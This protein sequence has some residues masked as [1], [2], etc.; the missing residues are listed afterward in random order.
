M[1]AREE[2]I[3]VSTLNLPAPPLSEL[4]DFVRV[5]ALVQGLSAPLVERTLARIQSPAGEGAGAWPYEWMQEGDRTDRNLRSL[6]AA[7]CF[8]LA[9]FPFV[10]GPVRAQALKRC[11]EVFQQW[12]R[13]ERV[14]LERIEVSVQG[15]KVPAYGAGL[16]QYKAPLL[17]VMGGVVALKE[18]WHNFL[19][20]S[21][22][23]RCPVIVVDFPGAGE[24]GLTYHANSHEELKQAL[25]EL[26][27]LA[28]TGECIALASS[29][30]GPLWLRVAL[31]D[32]RVRGVI[33]H[34]SPIHDFFTDP[35]WWERVPMTTKLAMAS[36]MRVPIE[37]VETL[38]ST[39]ALPREELSRLELP[40]LY[41]AGLRDEIIPSADWELVEASAP[42]ARV[43]RLD[44]VHG[45]PN[46]LREA[47]L[48][49]MWNVL[50][51]GGKHRSPAGLLVGSMRLATNLEPKLKR[52]RSSS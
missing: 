9:R 27:Q 20:A 39:L 17:L 7:S 45:T 33:L 19:K 37:Q 13:T 36:C 30:S 34:G 24:S 49:I 12:A 31:S 2:S 43:F 8:N 44:D 28:G 4:K 35:A 42:R 1:M 48:E 50:R 22:F 51:I 15:R 52:F 46:R 5:H 11:I 18:Q 26:L 23:I 14:P 10:D 25:G 40:V 16:G 47:A 41:V 3:H 32:S 21:R 29:F 6:D 38:K